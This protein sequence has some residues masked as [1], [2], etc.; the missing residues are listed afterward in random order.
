MRQ[1]VSM[2]TSK[3]LTASQKLALDTILRRPCKGIGICWFN[4]AMNTA[5]MATRITSWPMRCILK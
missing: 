2:G 1:E 3:D 5:R 4:P